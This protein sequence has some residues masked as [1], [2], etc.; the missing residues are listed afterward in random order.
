MKNISSFSQSVMVLQMIYI[1]WNIFGGAIMITNNFNHF[2]T[3]LEQIHDCLATE[4]TQICI[5]ISY[6]FNFFPHT[7]AEYT[8][9]T[10]YLNIRIVMTCLCQCF[11]TAGPRPGTG[12]WHHLY[13]AA[14]DSPGI[15]NLFKSNFIFVNMPHRTHNCTNTLYDYAII[16][17]QYL[18]Q[19]NVWT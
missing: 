12:P 16:N 3:N 13:R 10:W 2:R 15:D 18:C 1:D 5:I 4:P 7:S 19:F 6:F 14:R 11:S 8:H 17:Y 9:V